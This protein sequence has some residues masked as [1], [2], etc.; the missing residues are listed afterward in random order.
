MTTS[1]ERSRR[2]R[3]RAAGEDVPFLRNGKPP[4][5]RNHG[6]RLAVTCWCESQVLLIPRSWVL[7]GQTDTCGQPGCRQ[8]EAA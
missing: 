8:T 6:P 3:A 2:S 1:T 7:E 5:T 4:G